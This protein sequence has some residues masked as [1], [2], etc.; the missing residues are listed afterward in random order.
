MG[1]A[2][3]VGLGGFRILKNVGG[4][5]DFGFSDFRIWNILALAV[6]AYKHKRGYHGATIQWQPWW[7]IPL[8]SA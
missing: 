4:L 1:L 2:I 6:R 7:G 3:L 8:D 5:S